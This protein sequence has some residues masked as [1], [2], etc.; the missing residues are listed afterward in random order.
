[1][2]LRAK[3]CKKAQYNK[4]ERGLGGYFVGIRYNI[5]NKEEILSLRGEKN[6]SGSRRK[7]WNHAVYKMW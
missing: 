1:M 3:V 5:E 4:I 6:V 7:I 2:R